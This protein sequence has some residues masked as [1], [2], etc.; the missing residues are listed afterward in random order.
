M[1]E[2][3]PIQ[4]ALQKI[5]EIT[6]SPASETCN[7]EMSLGRTLAQEIHSPMDLPPF[8][9]SSMDG[10]AVHRDDLSLAT[11]STPVRLPVS[12]DIP[13]GVFQTK[14]LQPGTAARILTG[15]PLPQGADAVVPLEFTDQNTAFQT[16]SLPDCV[17][18]YMCPKPGENV[19]PAGEDLQKGQLVLKPGRIL[20]PQDVGL[21]ISLGIR[22][23]QV[24]RKPR[25]AVFSSGDELVTPDR[26]LEPGKIYDT[27]RYVLTGLLEDAGAEVIQLPIARD[28][29]K[30]VQRVLDGALQKQPN[31]ILSSAGV[32]VGVFDYV[33]KVIEENGNLE[34]WRVNMRPGKPV[35]FGDYKGTAFLGL[36]GNPVSAYIGCVVFV[37]PIVRHL[38]G[39]PPRSPRI[40]HA[41]LTESLNSDD[42]RES[43]YRG[44]INREN[45]GYT[46]KL[47]GHQGSGNL[48]S[49]VQANSLLIVPAG[50]KL[51][52]AGEEVSACPL[53]EE[54]L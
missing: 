49:L 16:Q 11:Q 30:S 50:V 26:T 13:A 37:L 54:D 14:V 17:S 46:A 4:T 52:K 1:T 47:A 27:N 29:P 6:K 44:I 25:I 53:D 5:I 43:Y 19:R 23:I 35:A 28:N 7:S 18:F 42:G 24:Y 36:P 31:L 41:V 15:A 45:D 51:I 33:R 8:T 48:Y 32:S 38:R 21:L 12:M 20:Q 39:L 34:F 40:I 22:E 10:F 2:L 3:L 9:N